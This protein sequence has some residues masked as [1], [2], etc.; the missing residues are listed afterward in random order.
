MKLNSSDV[1]RFWNK[2][3]KIPFHSCWEWTAYKNEYE[4]GRISIG[5]RKGRPEKAHRVSYFLHYGNLT[6]GLCILHICDNPG[7]VNPTHLVEGT[8]KDNSQDMI[9]KGRGKGQFLLV[10]TRSDGIRR[11]NATHCK[12]GHERTVENIYISKDG[13]K[14]CKVCIRENK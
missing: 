11:K 12:R 8:K 2:V 9:A 3:E 1:Q 7:C 5:G 13:G 4:Y 6:D 10:D 14:R